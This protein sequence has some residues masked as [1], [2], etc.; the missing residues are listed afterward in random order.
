MA[1]SSPRDNFIKHL[2]PARIYKNGAG[3]KYSLCMGGITSYLLFVL[4]VTGVLLMLHYEPTESGAYRSISDITFAI[5]YGRLIRNIHYWA[6]QGMIIT[7]CLHMIRVFFTGAYQPPRNLNWLVG[8]GLLVFTFLD[9]FTG[10]VLRWDQDTFWAARLGTE[11]LKEIPLA[12]TSLHS[13]AVG[14]EEMGSITVLRF[15]V[16]HCMILPLCLYCMISYH[17]WRIR[18]DGGISHPL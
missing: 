6:G 4:T 11:L 14:G 16:F 5:P 3:F 8:L 1:R 9:D 10:Y 12:G 17:F 2:H 7:I 15:Y 18:R 13:L